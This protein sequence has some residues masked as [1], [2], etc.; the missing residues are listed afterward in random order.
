MRAFLADLAAKTGPDGAPGLLVRWLTARQA[1]VRCRL[2]VA[3]V[4]LGWPHCIRP[5]GTWPLL[6]PNGAGRAA[7]VEPYQG[8]IFDLRVY[9][10]QP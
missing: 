1:S 9:Y 7:G 8:T 2:V 5:G 10:Q 3:T 4:A 6:L